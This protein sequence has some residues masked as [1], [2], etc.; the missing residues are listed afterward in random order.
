MYRTILAKARASGE[1]SKKEHAP[2]HLYFAG[3]GG[4]GMFP[5]ASLAHS[6][7]YHV[8]GFD[9]RENKNVLRLREK[10]ISVSVGNASLP[11]QTDALVRSL[12]VPLTH[13]IC[14]EA[15]E[16]SIPI[17]LRSELLAVLE[18]LFPCRIA[19]SGSHGK[20][21][22][23]GMCAS[24]LDAAGLSPTVLVGADLSEKE[25]GFREGKGN[26]LLYEACEYGNSFLAFSPT[27]AAVLNA[28]WEHTDFFEDENAVLTS[29]RRF[30]EK[31]SVIYRL[32]E[33]TLSLCA[34]ADFGKEGY[35]HA[36]SKISQEGK[37]SFSLYEGER[38][39]GAV[40]LGVIGAYQVQNALA[41]TALA[42]ACGADFNA[43]RK[44]LAAFRGVGARMEYKGRVGASPLYLDYAHHPTELAE[45][46]SAAKQ[47]CEKIVFVFEPHT[48]SRVFN[49]EKEYAKLL[50]AEKCA[51]LPI[52]A[53]REENVYGVSSEKLAKKSGA[54]CLHSFSEAAAF[55]S[56]HAAPNTLLLL[57]GAGDVA[58]VLP[59]LF[60]E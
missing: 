32:K 41:A 58:K 3:I 23:V 50:A 46:I 49:F 59:H 16:R 24:I 20:S 38:N 14:I 56:A 40:K 5:L 19:V 18:R 10:G 57:I 43:V 52:Y 26:I 54:V 25:G 13:P 30:L 17:F 34:D 27:H 15:Q 7:G 36:E 45:T 6:L 21:S 51:V 53:A 2:F 60:T 37:Y 35:Y 1:M 9:A 12:A 28:E 8:C 48:Y 4:S 42:L 29:F 39:L 22:T 44:G 47:L 31:P 11:P 55:L 33:E